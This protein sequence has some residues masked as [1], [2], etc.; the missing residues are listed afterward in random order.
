MNN[1]Q[2]R[3]RFENLLLPLMNDAYNLARW[4]MKNQEDAEDMV[5]ES[6]LRAFRFFASFHEGTN[7]RAWLLRIVRNTCYSALQARKQR[8]KEVPI[9][10]ENYG[11]EDPSP[12]PPAIL[13]TKA[14]VEAVR[15][16]IEELPV[17][18]REALVLR[19][20]EGLSYK[21]I[22]D[23]SG[24]PLGTVMS[25]LARARNQL[26]LILLKQKEHDTI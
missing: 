14:T 5:Q 21:E 6:Y 8:E 13:D 18:F 12:L 20:L 24:V 23:V 10:E 2:T 9:E 15:E 7:C 4:L 17:D 16:A 11:V 1:E 22:A 26:S 3:A 25:R 19:E